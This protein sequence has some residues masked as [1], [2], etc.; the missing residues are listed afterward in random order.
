M[1][2]PCINCGAK[3]LLFSELCK[4]CGGKKYI[5]WLETYFWEQEG[6]LTFSVKGHIKN[7]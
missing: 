7:H 4:S 3:V 1:Y 2:S 6:C 5:L